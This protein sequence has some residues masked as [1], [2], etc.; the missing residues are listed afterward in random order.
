MLLITVLGTIGT[1][2]GLFEDNHQKNE[3]KKKAIENGLLAKSEQQAKLEALQNLGFAQANRERAD[4]Q[5]K[6]ARKAVEDYLVEITEDKSLKEADFHDLRERLLKLAVPFYE[7]FLEEPADNSYVLQEQAR[8]MSRLGD[9]QFETGETQQSLGLFKQSLETWTG[10]TFRQRGVS[11]PRRSM[12]SS[13]SE[14]DR[15]QI[16]DSSLSPELIFAGLT[17]S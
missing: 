10:R 9:I 8:A 3:A 14:P 7:A 2:V 15:R 16:S 5:F 1:T 6:L 12:V 11:R 4:R 17:S 13:C